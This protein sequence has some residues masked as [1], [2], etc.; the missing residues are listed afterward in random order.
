MELNG[1]QMI[2]E[3]L[4]REGV[5]HIFGLPGGSN[6]PLYDALPQYPQMQHILVK[7]EQC[8]AHAADGYAR[9]TGKVGVC[10]ATSGPGATNLVTGIANA[11]MD[12]VPMVAITGEVVTGLI[13][14]DGFQEADITGITLPITKHNYL[15]L[16]AHDLPGMMREAFYIASTG[17]PGPV[18]IDVPRDVFQ[19]RAEF[20]YPESVELRGYRPN[21]VA[22]LDQL[23]KAAELIAQSERPLILAGHGVII[24]H[25]FDELREFAEKANIPVSTTLLGI[26]G[27]PGSHPLN[28]GMP[29][30]HG[31]YWNNI[32]ISESDLVLGIGMRFD[33]RV[34][35]RL[36][37]FA[38][39]AKIIH[40][41]I[42]AAEIGKN[43]QPAAALHGDVKAVLSELN[44]L[45]AHKER[46][47]WFARLDEL[48]REHPSVT[49]RQT[50]EV[51]PQYVIQKIYECS[52]DD[53]YT[54]TGVGQHQMWAAQYYRS[55]KPGRFVTSGGL[56]TMGF[57]VA[58]ALGVQVAKPGELVW[59][60]CG[61]GGFQMTLQN[62]A[63]ISEHNLPIKFAIMNN[64]FLGM[65]RQWQT[66]FYGDRRIA[67]PLKNPDFVKL[68]EAYDILGL[69]VTDKHQVESA[70]YKAIDH[71]G[72]VIVDF[73]VHG[74][75]NL[76][77]M[78]PPGA[79]LQETIDL[80]QFEEEKV[81]T[82]A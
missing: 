65:V 39:G 57:E 21:A 44:K 82:T 35:G 14:R 28:L 12:S 66:L 24:S 55:D 26:G 74:E 78:V 76:F 61:D 67:T 37:D 41:D 59:S 64:S 19:Q 3:C 48:K 75:E 2:L 7:H 25:A 4:A 23:D 43:V 54:V 11:W 1:A 45:I 5:E 68:A 81:V 20:V 40:V 22:D 10:F 17:R 70:I 27:F 71:A 29:G 77:P 46:P 32:A 56:G 18:L 30:M 51:L 47:D 53:F 62:L 13:G 80:P 73:Q 49:I 60:I 42:D 15:A 72:P 16:D 52:G 8:A 31:M 50:D 69:R 36:R 58:A 6:L 38:P 34:T 33:D 79:A 9:V 63:V